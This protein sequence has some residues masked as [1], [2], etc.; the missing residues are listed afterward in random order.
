MERQRRYQAEQMAAMIENQRFYG[1]QQQPQLLQ[2]QLAM[3]QNM[4]WNQRTGGTL[5]LGNVLGGILGGL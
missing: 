4:G 1:Q 5:G 3:Q 2:Q